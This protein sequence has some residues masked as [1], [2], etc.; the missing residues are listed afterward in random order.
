MSSAA[1]PATYTG[2]IAVSR[3]AQSRRWLCVGLFVVILVINYFDRVTLSIGNP[4]IRRD[5]GLSVVQMGFQIGR[6]HV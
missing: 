1:N 5:L 3:R 2:P 4:E 6:A